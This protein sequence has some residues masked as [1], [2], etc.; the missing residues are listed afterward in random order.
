MDREIDEVGIITVAGA[1][2]EQQCDAFTAIIDSEIAS[3]TNIERRLHD[4]PLGNATYR[5]TKGYKVFNFQARHPAAMELVAFPLALD[6]FRRYLGASM[7]L[8]SSE[9]AVIPPG[10]GRDFP[11]HYD[12]YDRIPGYF[13]S[14][15]AIF[16]LCDANAENGATR[17]IPGTHKE[18]LSR[19]EAT[20]RPWKHA[21]VKKG[22]LVLFNPYLFHA[23]SENRSNANRPTIINYYQRSYIKQG[24]DYPRAMSIAE[25][26]RLTKDQRTLLG[27]DHRVPTDVHELY[28]QYRGTNAPLADMDPVGR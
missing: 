8:H 18:F 2:S 7:V 26:R 16:Y 3:F 25:Q 1:L 6:Y 14:M 4:W 13:L 17:Y 21:E 9:G 10:C 12:G 20:Q 15:N 19:Q 28:L 5:D 22:D 24:F 27:F 11:L 23:G